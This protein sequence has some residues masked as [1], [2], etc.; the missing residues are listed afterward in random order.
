MSNYGYIQHNELSGYAIAHHGI[1]GQK[2]GVRRYQNEDGSLTEEGKRRYLNGDGSLRETA[3]TD[4]F[5]RG[6]K[7]NWS[8]VQKGIGPS[9]NKIDVDKYKKYEQSQKLLKQQQKSEKEN[10]IKSSIK[11]FDSK[12]NKT[13]NSIVKQAKED[14]KEFDDEWGGK[15]LTGGNEIWDYIWDNFGDDLSKEQYDLIYDKVCKGFQDKGIG[16]YD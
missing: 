9:A 7:D 8:A 14:A 13:V 6:F 15:A 4:R 12:L 11:S 5:M 16:W 3:Y 10:R 2:W 1:K